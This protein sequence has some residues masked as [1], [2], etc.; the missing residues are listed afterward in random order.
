MHKLVT[1][2]LLAMAFGMALLG[3]RTVA[4]ETLTIHAY[5]PERTTVS[6]SEHGELLFTSNN[7]AA[8]LA[9]AYLQESTLL[10]VIAR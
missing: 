6:F 1:L 10:S 2:V 4:S 5:I 9:V 3:A 7:P 8:S